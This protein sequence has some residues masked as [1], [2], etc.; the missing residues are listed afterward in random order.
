[1]HAIRKLQFMVK[2]YLDFTRNE[3]PLPPLPGRLDEKTFVITGGNSGIGFEAAQSAAQ[4]GAN[5]V[6]ICRSKERGQ[7]AVEKIKKATQNNNVHLVLC[8]LGEQESM[9]RAANE[10]K[11]NF[12]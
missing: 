9:Q 1:M 5:V 11:N 12:K 10:L 7:E 6:L 4:Q 3:K 8:E 2:G